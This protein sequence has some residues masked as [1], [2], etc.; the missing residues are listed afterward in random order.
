MT[1][2]FILSDN[3]ISI[4]IVNLIKDFYKKELKDYSDNIIIIIINIKLLKPFVIA[5]IIVNLLNIS[6]I[7]IIKDRKNN[8][9]F[10]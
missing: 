6:S 9:I 10:S 5:L 8:L 7:A 4:I 2:A 1:K 3:I